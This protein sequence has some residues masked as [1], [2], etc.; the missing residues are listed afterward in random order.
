M[1]PSLCIG[2]RTLLNDCNHSGTAFFLEVSNT[3]PHRGLLE[4]LKTNDGMHESISPIATV[5]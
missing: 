4:Y 2:P 5:L 1:V 3:V